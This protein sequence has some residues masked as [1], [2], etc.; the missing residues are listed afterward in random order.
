MRLNV[1]LLRKIQKIIV[2][3]PSGFNMTIYLFVPSPHQLTGDE[4]AGMLLGSHS[5][6]TVGC[7]AGYAT[8]MSRKTKNINYLRVDSDSGAVALGIA[9][10][11]GEYTPQAWE[12][13][14]NY[15]WDQPFKKRYEE[16]K[17]K[18]ER[19]QVASDYID[20]FIEKYGPKTRKKKEA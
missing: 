10:E 20:H 19:S 15:H 12:L 3:D 8:A 18:E 14:H 6:G 1:N 11:E 2:E 4:S 13:F 5:C 9:N 7:I 16:A 17:S